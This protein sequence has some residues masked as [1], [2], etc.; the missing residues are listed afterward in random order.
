MEANALK[1]LVQV[2]ET[3]AERA[4]QQ[5]AKANRDL[6][7]ARERLTL[8]SRFQ[9]EYQARFTQAMADGIDANSIGNYRAFLAQLG[10]AIEEQCRVVAQVDAVR[11]VA[12]RDW[13]QKQHRVKSY[14]VLIER[15]QAEQARAAA[16]S[17]QRQTDE[18]AA[19]LWQRRQTEQSA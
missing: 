5:L 10:R 1:L 18:R 11:G 6:E 7:R 9:S 8:L 16:R 3:A 12:E 2:S 13:R 17:E 4:A 14:E 15:A 19:G